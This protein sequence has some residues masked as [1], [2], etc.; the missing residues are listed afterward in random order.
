MD[1]DPQPSSND[2]EREAR[3]E[4]VEDL[5]D[6][7]NKGTGVG[8]EAGASESPHDFVERRMREIRQ[9]SE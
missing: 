3:R 7:L 1:N 4:A 5:V 6:D 8:P 9:G 2:V